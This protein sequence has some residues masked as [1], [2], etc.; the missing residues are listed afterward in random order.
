MTSLAG[1]NSII[2]V[3]FPSC[4][5]AMGPDIL[6]LVLVCEH[7]AAFQVHDFSQHSCISVESTENQLDLPSSS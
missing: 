1:G 2:Y 3:K 7:S 6:R 5:V 4:G